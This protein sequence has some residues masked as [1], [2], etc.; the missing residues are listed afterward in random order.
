MESCV[1]VV[2]CG[3]FK[4]WADIVSAEG[5]RGICVNDG[6]APFSRFPRFS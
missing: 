5:M 6:G 4:L 3:G 2:V 1:V